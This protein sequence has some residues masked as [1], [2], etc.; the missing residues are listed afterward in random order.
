MNSLSAKTCF[1]K[2]KID[3]PFALKLF[4]T[5]KSFLHPQAKLI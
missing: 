5:R 1:L 2:L 3:T 4:K